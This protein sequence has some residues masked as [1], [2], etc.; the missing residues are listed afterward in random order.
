MYGSTSLLADLLFQELGGR[1]KKCT[2]MAPADFEP[3]MNL[4]GPK[5]VKNITRFRAA[6]PVQERLA[7]TFRFK[8]DWQ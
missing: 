7:V 6:I 8:R 3:L 5:I 2:L 4:V 1:L